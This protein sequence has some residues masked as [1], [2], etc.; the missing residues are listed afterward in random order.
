MGLEER[1]AKAAEQITTVMI[2]SGFDLEE[3]TELLRDM[4]KDSLVG[5]IATKT[6]HEDKSG[7]TKIFTECSK[8]ASES[9]G[10]LRKL[11]KVWE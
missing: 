1:K 7:Y 8:L 5:Q 11:V 6:V 2:D 10:E 3:S 4:F 9:I